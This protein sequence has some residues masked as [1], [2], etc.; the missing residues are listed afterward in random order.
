MLNLPNK[1]STVWEL[2]F[3]P[4]CCFYPAPGEDS[5]CT[6]CSWGSEFADIWAADA[7]GD[8]FPRNRNQLPLWAWTTLSHP[9]GVSGPSHIFIKHCCQVVEAFCL[10]HGSEVLQSHWGRGY[11]IRWHLQHSVLLGLSF[12]CIMLFLHI[13]HFV[14]FVW[15]L[16]SLRV[17]FPYKF[18]PST[19]A[20]WGT[21]PLWLDTLLQMQG[22]IG[23]HITDVLQWIWGALRKEVSFSPKGDS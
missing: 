5:S 3:E 23:L 9:W 13:F 17:L 22:D 8:W 10:S 20:L 2:L 7:Q 19:T 14:L 16:S 4:C 11:T 15:V 18:Y 6:A 21:S 12:R 1:L